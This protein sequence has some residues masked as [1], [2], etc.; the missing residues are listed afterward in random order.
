MNMNL[1]KSALGLA[2]VIG[3]SLGA[4]EQ[5][6]ANVYARSYVDIDNLFIAITNGAGDPTGVD[7]SINSY[8]NT[9]LGTSVL[10]GVLGAVEFGNCTLASC[11]PNVMP[12]LDGGYTWVGTDPGALNFTPLG[13]GMDEYGRADSVVWESA[14]VDI[15][16]GGDPST[17]VTHVEQISEAE[18]QGGT[19][20]SAL[21]G[22]TSTTGFEVNFT[23]Q[24]DFFFTASF[25]AMWD[26]LV[27]ILP[28]ISGT[29]LSDL[30]SSLVL[31]NEGTGEELNWDP[32]SPC[33]SSFSLGCLSTDPGAINNVLS[34][35]QSGQASNIGSGFFNVSTGLISAG[36]YTLG[37][38]LQSSVE[39][40]QR[41]PAPATLGLFGLGL[42]L[43][44]GLSR[45]RKLR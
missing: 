32:G 36:T 22:I 21:T 4:V 37:L 38:A 30:S 13:P 9:I 42:T 6:S 39:V 45:R 1:K 29:A 41:I 31:R 3:A 40:T 17:E 33:A 27:Q 43:L 34:I 2:L 24:D 25:D 35:S 18:L 23:V 10:N 14:I 26:Q 16:A 11:V 20:G 19:H 28:G 8:T 5:A 12:T 15:A 44:A 7:V